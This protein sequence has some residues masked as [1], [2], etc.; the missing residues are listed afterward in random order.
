MFTSNIIIQFVFYEE[1]ILHGQ[2]Q[3]REKLDTE[4]QEK[5]DRAKSLTNEADDRVSLTK[6]ETNSTSYHAS[7]KNW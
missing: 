2:K 4:A 7:W 3:Y 6:Q 5:M 1:S